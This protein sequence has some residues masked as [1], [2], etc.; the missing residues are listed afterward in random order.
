MKIESLLTG[1]VSEVFFEEENLPFKYSVLL[2]KDNQYYLGYVVSHLSIKDWSIM[3]GYT[4]EH[5]YPVTRKA[6][7]SD[8]TDLRLTGLK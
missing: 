1:N 4:I 8:K 7:K 5:V 3:K 2:S 6:N